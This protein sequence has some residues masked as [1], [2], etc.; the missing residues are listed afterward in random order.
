MP[1]LRNCTTYFQTIQ[2]QATNNLKSTSHQTSNLPPSQTAKVAQFLIANDRERPKVQR[3]PIQLLFF[4]LKRD[5]RLSD[6]RPIFEASQSGPTVMLY[7][8][9]PKR[10]AIRHFPTCTGL[11]DRSRNC[12]TF[13]PNVHGPVPCFGPRRMEIVCKIVATCLWRCCGLSDRS[14]RSRLNPSATL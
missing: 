12:R 1:P 11:G 8:F 2:N 13:V 7:V 4:W 9:E 14:S 10:W 5:L 6:H 3:T